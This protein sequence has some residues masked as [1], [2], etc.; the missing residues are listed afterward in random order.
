MS[1]ETIKRKINPIFTRYNVKRAAVFGSVARG[2]DRPGSDV[3]I[4]VE[5]G[6]NPSLIQL[7]RMENEIKERKKG[8]KK[9][10]RGQ[11]PFFVNFCHLF[12]FPE[13]SSLLY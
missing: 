2:E 12:S 6:K 11:V 9:E 13:V 3:D 8:V 5:F 10:E 7:I 1:V 4:L